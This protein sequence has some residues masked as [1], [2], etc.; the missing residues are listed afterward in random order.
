MGEK[1]IEQPK[2]VKLSEEEIERNA[3]EKPKILEPNSVSLDKILPNE[4][5]KKLRKEAERRDRLIAEGKGHL[6]PPSDS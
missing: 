4:E 6:I 1:I 5:V 2:K 3:K